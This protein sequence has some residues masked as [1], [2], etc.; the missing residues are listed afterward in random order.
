M[1]LGLG[2]YAYADTGDKIYIAVYQP[3]RDEITQ[4]ASKYLEN[5]M[6]SLITKY[7]IADEDANN[8]FVITAKLN[9]TSKD[10]VPSTPQRISEKIDFTFIIGDI[11]E[12][13]VFES[14][15]IS[16]IGVDINETKA[17]ISA[18]KKI[19]IND[20][21]FKTFIDNARQKI[22]S[23]Y[24]E[25]CSEII[26]QAKQDATNRD[27]D[28]AIYK[29]MQ[30]PSICDCASECQ[31]LEIEFY[32]KRLDLNAER[33]LNRAK[34]LWA[35]SPT[36][37][38]A[39]S[40]ADVIAQIPSGTS[41]QKD[42]DALIMDIESKLKEDQRNEWNFKMKQYNDDIAREKRQDAMK[43]R[44]QIADNEYRAKQQ[45]ADNEYRAK[46]QVADSEYRARQQASDNAARSQYIEACRQVGL[47]YARN[48]PRTVVYRKNVY[49][50]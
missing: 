8:R 46:Q 11:I 14:L 45:A 16:S 23:Y 33:L 50:W 18:I 43:A 24:S 27:F 48:Q 31:Q 12:N 6:R 9:I 5:K 34:A 7:G 28:A 49:Y 2:I 35:S 29:L 3:E 22:V 30:I 15:C 42:I 19:N 32:T 1:L 26:V 47:E 20:E 44:Q 4:E 17:F 13:K 38:G 21:Q 10:I 39:S 36:P 41:S 40:A 25:R 37:E